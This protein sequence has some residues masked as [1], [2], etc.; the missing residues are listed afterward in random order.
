M[1]VW[2]LVVCGGVGF[3]L[4]TQGRLV[5]LVVTSALI[6]GLVMAG[7]PVALPA[8]ELAALDAASAFFTILGLIVVLQGFF[9][10]GAGWRVWGLRF[11]LSDAQRAPQH[12]GGL[13]V[14]GLRTATAREVGGDARID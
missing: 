3:V 12:G 8:A 2:T 10:V 14:A 7:L 1:I 13:P 5:L 9:L 4:G 11:P 6:A